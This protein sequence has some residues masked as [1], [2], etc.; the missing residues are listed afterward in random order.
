VA[1]DNVDNEFPALPE[2]HL[3]PEAFAIA[4]AMHAAHAD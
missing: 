3:R 1:R 4:A 2:Q